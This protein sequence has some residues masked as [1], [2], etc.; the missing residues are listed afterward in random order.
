MIQVREAVPG[1]EPALAALERK[2]LQRAP[3][4]FLHE[5]VPGLGAF[6]SLQGD[7]HAVWVAEE[8]GV[9]VGCIADS[10]RRALFDGIERPVY[11]LGGLRVSPDASPRTGFAL[12]TRARQRLEEGGH[13]LGLA[14]VLSGNAQGLAFVESFTRRL[15]EVVRA[16]EASASVPPPLPVYRPTGRSLPR[17]A[18][19]EDLPAIASLLSSSFARH[20]GAP[21]FS[22]GWLAGTLGRTPGL[23]IGDFRVVE[24]GGRL[25]ATA[26]FW[27]QRPVRRLCIAGLDAPNRWKARAWSALARLSRGVGPD[28]RGG[29]LAICHLRFPAAEAGHEAAL[30][31]LVRAELADARF[32]RRFA[33]LFAGFHE[34]DPLRSCLAGLVRFSVPSTVLLTVPK[35]DPALTAGT[36]DPRR[37]YYVD[38][39]LV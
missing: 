29:P 17:A 4:V 9:V 23:S 36:Y 31:D 10:T 11:Y 1:D 35:T 24:E 16:G 5:H 7:E 8:D 13:G 21:A 33:A 25:V 26:A 27:D 6:L 22:A 38:L 3:V 37:P 12:M 19:D 20:Y 32:R 39:S 34:S 2:A 28:T 14:V 15:H 30:A 18:R